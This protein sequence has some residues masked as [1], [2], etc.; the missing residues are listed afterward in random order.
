MISGTAE[1]L[2]AAAGR[3]VT[4]VAGTS[5]SND[6]IPNRLPV[7]I[8]CRVGARQ[9]GAAVRHAVVALV[10]LAPAA[11]HLIPR[12]DSFS[13]AGGVGA[14]QLAGAVGCWIEAWVTTADTTWQERTGKGDPGRIA[15]TVAER[16]RT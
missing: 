8:T 5:T 16:G 11:V 7:A 13:A 3:V 12:S 10:A 9:R 1:W 15:M 2:Q 4:A 14:G 6:E